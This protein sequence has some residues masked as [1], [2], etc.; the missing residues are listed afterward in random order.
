MTEQ[1][2]SRGGMGGGMG[3]GMTGHLPAGGEMT[4]TS[5]REG[6]LPG[7]AVG[8]AISKGRCMFSIGLKR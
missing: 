1:L 7:S 4:G 3:G 5:R 6:V 2:P 8:T